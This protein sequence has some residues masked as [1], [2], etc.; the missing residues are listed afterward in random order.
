MNIP[1]YSTRA[2][3]LPEAFR[4]SAE[5]VR[6]PFIFG[7]MINQAIILINLLSLMFPSRQLV[8]L[9]GSFKTMLPMK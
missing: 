7:E 1:Q 8:E 9:K 6:S 3:D 5:E 2:V 4:E